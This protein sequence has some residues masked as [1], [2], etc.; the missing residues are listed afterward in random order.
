MS[1]VNELIA[2]YAD[3]ANRLNGIMSDRDKTAY[4]LQLLIERHA[5]RPGEW[6]TF[7]EL[8][9]YP[10]GGQRIDFFAINCWHSKGYKAI[11]YEIKVSRSD[12][13]KEL[14]QPYKR[15]Y[16]ERV[17]NECYFVAPKG[18]IKEGELPEGWGLIEP[19]RG[20]R[21]LRVSSPAMK[22]KHAKW[23]VDFMVSLARR[24]AD[25]LPTQKELWAL[26]ATR[27]ATELLPSA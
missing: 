20:A 3:M 13:L 16:A 26:Q 17:S 8:L 22:R 1:Y 14:R 15:L 7:A 18:L 11:S 12:F 21:Y 19:I 4:L 5:E 10:V 27:D 25:A 9:E 24:S 2:A 6:A 23:S